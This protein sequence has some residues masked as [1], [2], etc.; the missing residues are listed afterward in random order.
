MGVG[1]RIKEARE[2]LG[3]TQRDLA[4]IV[5][6]TPGAIGN[7]EAETSHPKEPVM[8]ALLDA[9]RVD[10]N[11]LFQDSYKSRKVE[12]SLSE[13]SHIEKY[14]AL[15]E[16]GKQIVD[17]LLEAEHRRVLGGETTEEASYEF[18]SYEQGMAIRKETEAIL[19]AKGDIEAAGRLVHPHRNPPQPKVNEKG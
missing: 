8:F 13:L 4:A 7:Y 9:L 19:R 12:C 1:K 2:A 6:V 17:L 5:G 11:F 18:G 14:R 3:I 10:A 16:H 15:D